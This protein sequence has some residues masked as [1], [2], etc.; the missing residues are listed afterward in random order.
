MF[1]LIDYIA[2]GLHFWYN[3]YIFKEI[4]RKSVSQHPGVGSRLMT[5][6]PCVVPRHRHNHR[7]MFVYNVKLKCVCFLFGRIHEQLMCVS[8]AFRR[9]WQHAKCSYR[10]RRSCFLDYR[11][12]LYSLQVEKCEQKFEADVGH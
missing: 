12:L 8:Y 9:A 11:E 10:V 5:I 2:Y 1:Y 7:N 4:C 6:R 3:I